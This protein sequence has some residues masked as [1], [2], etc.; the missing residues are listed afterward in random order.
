MEMER[1][2]IQK[3]GHKGSSSWETRVVAVCP[4]EVDRFMMIYEELH[5]LVSCFL[6]GGEGE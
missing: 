6:W 5:D 1:P 3:M 4:K 2:L